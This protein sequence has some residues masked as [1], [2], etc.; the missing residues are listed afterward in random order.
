MCDKYEYEREYVR[1]LTV[2][3]D[4][5]DL[6]SEVSPRTEE[7]NLGTFYTSHRRYT[8]PDKWSGA[9]DDLVY[10]VSADLGIR[11]APQRDYDGRFIQFDTF[12]TDPNKMMVKARKQGHVVLPVWMYG[13]SGVA[14]KAADR[15]PFRCSWDSG[16]VGFIFVAAEDIRRTY[17]V[18][19]ITRKV[20]AQAVERLIAEVDRYSHW[21]AG[22][23]WCWRVED[24]DGE[25]LES[26]GGYIGGSDEA[27]YCLEEGVAVAHAILADRWRA[28]QNKLKQLIRAR[29]PLTTRGA[30]LAEAAMT[31]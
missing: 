20:R 18:S 26:C 9:N 15:N 8:S 31:S 30:V 11:P 12:E 21:A 28:R 1:D 13:H 14:Y 25:V 23:V 6:G 16:M 24:A 29:A 10:Q 27:D 7:C 2:I 22:D 17:G 4:R 3:V 5:D 19:R